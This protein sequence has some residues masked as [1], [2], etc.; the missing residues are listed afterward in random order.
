[1]PRFCSTLLLTAIIA[2]MAGCERQPDK[3]AS[4]VM[5]PKPVLAADSGITQPGAA[6]PSGKKEDDFLF[7][8]SDSESVPEWNQPAQLEESEL[9][10]LIRAVDTLDKQSRAVLV[11]IN[12]YNE[13]FN[14]IASAQVRE[15]L[16]RKL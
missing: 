11:R 13:H 15:A 12:S 8:P 1:M 10:K 16:F 2:V 7:D 14:A 5:P 6:D 9:R 3:P 4:P